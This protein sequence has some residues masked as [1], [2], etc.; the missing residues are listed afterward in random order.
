MNREKP[1]DVYTHVSN[2]VSKKIKNYV[3][4]S[5]D[6]NHEIAKK[7]DEKVKRKIVKQTVMT[8]V[9]GVTFI[10]AKDQIQRQVKDYQLVEEE[11][12]FLASKFLATLT[13]D[14]IKD[15]FSGA[16]AIKKWLIRCK[17][18]KK[19]AELIANSG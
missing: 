16:H 4:N 5:K 18:H 7:L 9:Y 11:D 12:Y 15:L 17:Y 8:S 13:L 14:A 3:S 6:S 10:G 2:M 1:G 19:G